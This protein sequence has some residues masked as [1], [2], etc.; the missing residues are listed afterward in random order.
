M[1]YLFRKSGAVHLSASLRRTCVTALLTLCGFFY[2]LAR[3]LFRILLQTGIGI[4]RV[5]H[6]DNVL[7]VLDNGL[8]CKESGVQD[9]NFVGIGNTDP[10][11]EADGEA[12]AG[13]AGRDTSSLRAVLF[14]AVLADALQHPNRVVRHH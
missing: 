7:W 11:P 2:R 3:S 6:I 9:P 13:W 5:T 4:F 14:H 8:H 10:N 1:S 12:S